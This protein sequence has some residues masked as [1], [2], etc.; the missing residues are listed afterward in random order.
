ML[1]CISV[2]EREREKKMKA[3]FSKHDLNTCLQS[4][5]TSRELNINKEYKKLLD[6]LLGNN[7]EM[8]SLHLCFVFLSFIIN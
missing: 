4:N 6:S 8:Y 1:L 2:R 7:S 3:D 5:R